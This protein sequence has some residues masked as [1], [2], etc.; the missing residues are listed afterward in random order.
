MKNHPTIGCCGI[1]C[2]LCPRF[3]SSGPSACPGCHGENFRDKHP[4]CGFVTCCVTKRGLEVCAG[5]EDYPC[6]RFEPEKAGYDSFVTHQRVFAN[7]DE[8]RAQGIGPFIAQQK[9]RMEILT[10]LLQNADDGRSKSFFCLA[11]ALLP[12]DRLAEL[13]EWMR[14]LPDD[15]DIKARNRLVR[16]RLTAMAEGLNITLKLRSPAST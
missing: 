3:H 1:D 4:S 15:L 11:C 8:I 14:S 12:V 10:W 13:Q 9:I 2:G 7:L 16:D 6:K 5:C